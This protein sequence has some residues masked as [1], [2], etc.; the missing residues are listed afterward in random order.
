MLHQ[1][2]HHQFLHLMGERDEL[3]RLI[4]ERAWNTVAMARDAYADDFVDHLPTQLGLS[5]ST[6]LTIAL[7]Y[8]NN[9]LINLQSN[10]SSISTSLPHASIGEIREILLQKLILTDHSVA[11]VESACA[12]LMSMYD[13]I[14][15]RINNGAPTRDSKHY[16]ED[17]DTF[18]QWLNLGALIGNDIVQY[19]DANGNQEL[20]ASLL[21]DVRMYLVT[22]LNYVTAESS[23]V[24]N[25]MLVS[26]YNT[27]G[28]YYTS[29]GDTNMGIQ[30]FDL[31][32]Q[33][34]SDVEGGNIFRKLRPLQS[35]AIAHCTT[36]NYEQG[37]NAYY[38][39]T[40]IYFDLLKDEKQIKEDYRQ[41]R[42]TLTHFSECVQRSLPNSDGITS[43]LAPSRSL[44]LW[45]MAEIL[46]RDPLL[47]DLQADVQILRDYGKSDM[48]HRKAHKRKKRR[49]R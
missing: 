3:R 46:L 37:I 33:T 31:S 14:K 42:F 39:A 34:F 8:Y 47:Q 23:V 10:L 19:T 5:Q 7:S 4:F 30:Y 32:V 26:H 11:E 22:L 49:V 16:H 20:V 17:V 24:V 21:T 36:K 1:E 9:R 28:A 2:S 35:L 45:R 43:Y 27:V 40:V 44:N 12:V 6:L 18:I 29:M 41:F 13:I 15:S 48:S 38:N 25:E